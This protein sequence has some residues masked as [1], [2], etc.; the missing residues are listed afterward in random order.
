M[1][2]CFR[3]MLRVCLSLLRL[4][5]RS[6][7]RVVLVVAATVEAGDTAAARVAAA[8][9]GVDPAAAVVIADRGVVLAGHRGAIVTRFSACV[10]AT[11]LPRFP[12]HRVV[13]AWESS[14]FPA[15]MRG[16][17]LFPFWI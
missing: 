5:F 6:G 8:T 16:R 12:L 1:S 17:S 14:A 15:R 4:L 11:R 10:M 3:P 7:V 13:A 2:S 9:G